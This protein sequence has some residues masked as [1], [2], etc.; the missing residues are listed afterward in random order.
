[1]LKTL[2]GKLIRLCCAALLLIPV[3]AWAQQTLMVAGGGGY[4]RPIDEIMKGFETG[5]DIKVER[6]YGNMGQ[7]LSQTHN[8]GHIAIVF[9][10][11]DFLGSAKQV[12]FEHFIPIGTGRL[13]LAW[14]KGKTVRQ[15]S[16]ISGAGFERIALPNTKMAVF[17]KA[18]MEYLKHS[19]EFD[20]VQKHLLVVGMVP[21]VS[22]Y[23]VSGEVDA[24]FINLTEALAIKDKIGGYIEIPQSEYTPISIVA[25]PVQGQDSEQSRALIAYLQTP[26]AREIIKRYGL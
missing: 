17:G 23:L 13:V 21:Q 7:V 16:D 9:G 5:H 14:S 26:A 12:Q 2:N 10:E 3:G 15:A 11:A 1:M 8:S 22:S 4:K 24:G 6:F 18:A 19:G 25:A 20:A